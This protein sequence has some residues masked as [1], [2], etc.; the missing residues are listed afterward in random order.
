MI[1]KIDSVDSFIKTVSEFREKYSAKELF[2]RGE[3]Q[4]YA[5]RVPSIYRIPDNKIALSSAQYYERLSIN[6]HRNS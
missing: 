6:S 1:H 5:Q 2:Y 3:S 4:K